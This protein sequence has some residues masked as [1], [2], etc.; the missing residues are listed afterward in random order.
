M[1]IV[2]VLDFLML[3]MIL[4][5]TMIIS[6]SHSFTHGEKRISIDHYLPSHL[7]P[8]YATRLFS[9]PERPH[10]LMRGKKSSRLVNRDDDG[11]GDDE[12]ED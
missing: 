9:L 7:S 3:L 6:F 4:M 5:M 2:P 10:K 1:L 11:D 12:D 8:S